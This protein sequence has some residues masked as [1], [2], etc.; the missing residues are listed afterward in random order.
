MG[1]SLIGMSWN[2]LRKSLVAGVAAPAL[3]LML[4]AC[5]GE[6]EV[7]EQLTE[8]AIEAAGDGA[9]VDIEED[10]VTVTDENG[11]EATIG[12]QLPEDFPVDDVPILEGTVLSATAV[13]GASYMVM[14]E[15]EGTPE[16]VQ[17]EA[18]GMLTDAGFT[19]NN[20]TSAEGFFTADLTKDGYQVGLSSFDNVGTTN[21]QY[22]V[23]VG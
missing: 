8:E 6:D 18:L 12:T 16:E 21:L 13:D 19:S 17:E 5:G 2:S 22:V 9:E 10:G 14:L 23:G 15:V 20:E 1:T 7:A 4:T 3:V 11:D